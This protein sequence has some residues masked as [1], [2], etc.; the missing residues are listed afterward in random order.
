M[1]ARLNNTNSEELRDVGQLNFDA[2]A[3]GVY[4]VRL[5]GVE[6]EVILER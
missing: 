5:H 3:S 6:D 1:I 2:I 4:E